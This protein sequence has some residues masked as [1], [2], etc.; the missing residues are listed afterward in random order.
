[1]KYRAGN[2]VIFK[3]PLMGMVSDGGFVIKEVFI[4]GDIRTIIETDEKYYIVEQYVG[5]DVEKIKVKHRDLETVAEV[6]GSSCEA[7]LAEL[8]DENEK[9]KKV[10]KYLDR[11]LRIARKSFYEAKHKLDTIKKLVD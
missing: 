2:K 5:D 7:E 10:N 8:R 1:M 3:K 6:Y 11:Q 9:L 4:P